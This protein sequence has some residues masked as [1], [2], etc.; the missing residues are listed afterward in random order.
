MHARHDVVLTYC[1]ESN[2]LERGAVGVSQAPPWPVV[3]RSCTYLLY[4]VGLDD[5]F[6]S[7]LIVSGLREDRG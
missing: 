4:L 1:H 2:D 6:W 3:N 7:K 5:A